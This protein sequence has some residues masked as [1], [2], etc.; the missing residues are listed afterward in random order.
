[1]SRQVPHTL[2]SLQVIEKLHAAKI[3]VMN[4]VGAP[5]HAEKALKL[6]VDLICC[7]VGLKF[8]AADG[9]PLHTLMMSNDRVARAVDTLA[10]YRQAYSFQNVFL[11]A[12]NINRR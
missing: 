6:G 12:N 9:L 4:M 7:Q 2:L 1:M 8:D 3:P 5:K 10:V 11:S